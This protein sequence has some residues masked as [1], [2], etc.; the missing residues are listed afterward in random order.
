MC[1]KDFQIMKV[2]VY[3][4]KWGMAKCVE[5]LNRLITTIRNR[6]YFCRML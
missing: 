6:E 4:M 5:K 1:N 3:F 2:L